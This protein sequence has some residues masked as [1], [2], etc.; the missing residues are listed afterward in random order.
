[1]KKYLLISL[2]AFIS[3]FF[4]NDTLFAQEK[5]MQKAKNQYDKYQ[6]IDAQETY[7]KIVKKGYKSADLFMNLGDSYYFNSQFKDALKWYGELV[8]S[9]PDEVKPEYY[10]R[11]AQTLKSVE[12]Y[13]EADKYMQKF[14]DL[15]NNDQRA[16][17]F[18]E[19]ADYL[20]QIDFQSGRYEVENLAVNSIF[21][22]FGAAFYGKKIVFSSS[23][24]TLRLNKNVHQWNDEAFLNIFETEYD[25]V[26][27]S[28]S[29]V[30]RLSGKINSKFHE[31]TPVFTKDEQTVY[32]TRNNFNDGKIGRDQKGTN[33][34]KIYRSYKT[35]QGG[36]TTPQGLPFNSDEY[37]VAHPTLS[38][39]EK[40]LY[41]SSDM[42]G[43][44]GLSDIYEVSIDEEGNFGE[45]K[46]LG[47]RINTESK[48]T[49]PFISDDNTLYF[50][51]DGHMGLGGLDVFVTSLNPQT[52]QEKKVINVGRPINGAKD[53]FAFI[54]NHGSKRGYFSSNR[55]GGKG[56]DDV[57]GFIEIEELRNPC[58]I[59]IA[60]LVTDKDTGE[61]LPGTKISVYDSSNTLIQ[62]SVVG[63][64]A[65]Y[66]QLV[67]CESKYF[68]RAEKDEYITLE[69]LVN[70]LA[71]TQVQ[72]TPLSL[73]KKIKSADIGDD[74]AKVLSLN[75][76]YF[77][78][79]GFEIRSDA[80]VELAK[81]I[82]VMNQHPKMKIDIRS[83]TDSH[84]DNAYNLYLSEKRA[85][86]TVNYIVDKGI[87]KDRLTGKGYGETK[88]VN[89]CVD[90]TNCT[91]EAHQLN[92]RS[93]F[94]IV[95]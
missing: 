60:G 50:S 19:G 35:D 33:K 68:V 95:K 92:R 86:A 89:D 26:N 29:K 39:D 83:H 45:P 69:K 41:F 94:I 75:P 65:T 42:P 51:S 10:F 52:K 30:K 84:G 64:E 59:T 44:K 11:Y 76:I 36:W 63:E 23:R 82:E 2:L 66:T 6:Y 15:S 18:A 85:E 28:F 43:G 5:K 49:F 25:S 93:E 27:N 7:L 8:N 88:P 54:I 70:T 90:N 1:M 58:E 37:S 3:L 71:E 9:Y 79:D 56:S 40:T 14:A 62:S 32:F 24:D 74:L 13:E 48:E 12:K 73:E 21:A 47:D 81:V 78:F 67:D 31:S 87:S 55:L 34:L 38:D 61:L 91:K 80:K 16:K 20:K 72:D 46:N 53:D 77:S 57:Y 4:A 22:D 17:L